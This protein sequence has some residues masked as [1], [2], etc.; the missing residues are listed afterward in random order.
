MREEEIAHLFQ[1]ML[2]NLKIKAKNL[3]AKIGITNPVGII[4]K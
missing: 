3:V 2:V 4:K 1:I